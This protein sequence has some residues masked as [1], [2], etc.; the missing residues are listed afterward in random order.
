[1]TNRRINEFYSKKK[2]GKGGKGRKEGRKERNKKMERIDTVQI[3]YSVNRNID[4]SIRI[5]IVPRTEWVIAYACT[6]VH[7]TYSTYSTYRTIVRISILRT[8][9]RRDRK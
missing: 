1:M 4:F 6:Q 2:R 9:A 8:N 5:G 7:S 3:R